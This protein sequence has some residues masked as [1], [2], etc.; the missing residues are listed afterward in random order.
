MTLSDIRELLVSVDPEIRHYH[1]T[2]DAEAYT[3]WQETQRLP[4]M[5]DD[6]HEEAWRFYV[7]RYTRVEDDEIA[8]R[9]F[10]ALDQCEDTTVRHLVDYDSE[11]GY[12]H[13]IYEC[14][15]Y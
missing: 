12:I 7:H 14:E 8:N 15:G 4:V 3:Y 1:S 11:S 6:E 10:E 13:H 9:L 5:A 2:S